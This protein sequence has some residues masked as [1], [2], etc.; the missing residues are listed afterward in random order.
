LTKILDN[1]DFSHG[2]GVNNMDSFQVEEFMSIRWTGLLHPI[3]AETYTIHALLSDVDE[4]ARVWVDQALII[5][6]WSSLESTKI[7]GT[8]GLWMS[9]EYYDIIIEYQQGTGSMG[10][11]L[12]WESISQPF[13]IVNSRNLI[14]SSGWGHSSMSVV[15][16]N[17]GLFATYYSDESLSLPLLS[18][19]SDGIE[20]DTRGKIL[21]LAEL[22]CFS[23]RWTGFIHPQDSHI[24]T[25][26]VGISEPDQRLR[27][28]IDNI[29]I[30]DM[31]ASLSGTEG[32]AKV[33]F[34]NPGGYYEIILEYKL[35]GLP[36]FAKLNWESAIF[37]K[38][39]I[40]L[41]NINLNSGSSFPSIYGS[42]QY[43]VS[44]LHSIP[45][46]PNKTHTIFNCFNLC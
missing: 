7:S 35:N 23:A 3:F 18:F 41:S 16:E 36:N 4:R 5:D 14:P 30:V 29:L 46:S 11:R 13:S 8:V 15:M 28:W 45:I 17:K 44:G 22:K 6:M 10:F 20:M 24:Y 42:S 19:V 31:W 12:M 21:S 1:V 25:M 39:S 40:A 2:F 38:Q 33:S 26:F 27:L 37:Q 9:G 43:T 32:S 34:D